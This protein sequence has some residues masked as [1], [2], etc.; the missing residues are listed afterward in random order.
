MSDIFSAAGL[1]VH[2]PWGPRK[3]GIPESVETPAPVRATTRRGPSIQ[4]RT[5]SVFF[6]A[7]INSSLRRMIEV[8][9]PLW[10]GEAELVRAYWTSPARTLE[11]D[12]LWLQ[13]QC[14]KEFW[15]SG[16]TKFDQGG[17][18]PGSL[19]RLTAETANIDR[20]MDRHEVLDPLEDVK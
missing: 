10:A 4:A 7:M 11:T 20:T 14:F 3:S 5:R 1:R 19:K 16:V 13:R 9:T 15:G 8:A 17:L 12:L 2:S 6:I 18:I